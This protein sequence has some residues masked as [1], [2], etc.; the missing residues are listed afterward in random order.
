MKRYVSGT[1]RGVHAEP[2]TLLGPNDTKE[3]FVVIED[4]D[5]GVT[6]GYAQ[7]GDI[8]AALDQPEPRSVAEARMRM[9]VQ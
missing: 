7:K 2:G 8:E 1:L 3:F 9:T 4:T 6:V 5:D